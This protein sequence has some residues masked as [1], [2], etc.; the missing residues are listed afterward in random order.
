[1]LN[2]VSLIGRLA[3]DPITRQTSAGVVVSFR[4]AVQRPT[5]DKAADFFNVSAFGKTAEYVSNYVAKGRLVVINGRLEVN[6]YK[7]KE[8][9]D[10]QSVQVVANT[11]NALE[12]GD[13]AHEGGDNRVAVA[14]A[15]QVG[16]LD[17]ISDPFA[18]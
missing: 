15:K 18:D 5:K 2:T 11:V 6:S 14:P 1:M 12:R 17:D 10:V 3:A 16:T 7:N 9:V 4:V 8:G 13:T